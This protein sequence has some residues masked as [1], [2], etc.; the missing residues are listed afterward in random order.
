MTNGAG[1]DREE[2]DATNDASFTAD[3]TTKTRR[4]INPATIVVGLNELIGNDAD[5][6]LTDIRR[7]LLAG[8]PIAPRR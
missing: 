4:H 2:P 8:G 6:S 3:G 1:F 5:I 7:E